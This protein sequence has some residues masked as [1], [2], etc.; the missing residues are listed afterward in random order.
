L[1]LGAKPF[2]LVLIVSLGYFSQFAYDMT[3]EYY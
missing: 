3:H 1:A 2:F